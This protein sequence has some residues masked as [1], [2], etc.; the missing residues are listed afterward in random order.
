MPVSVKWCLTR[1]GKPAPI[2][3]YRYEDVPALFEV[4][5]GHVGRKVASTKRNVS[6]ERPLD[7]DREAIAALP[8]MRKFIEI[9]D[10]IPFVGT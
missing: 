2:T 6:P 7:V 1:G 8:R 3:F 5:S 10:S 9:Y 4:L